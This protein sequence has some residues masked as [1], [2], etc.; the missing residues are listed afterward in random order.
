M[1][2]AV[3]QA[4]VSSVKDEATKK[5]FEYLDSH[6]QFD[7]LSADLHGHFQLQGGA[8]AYEHIDSRKLRDA[9]ANIELGQMSAGEREKLLSHL[10]VDERERLSNLIPSLQNMEGFK[11]AEIVHKAS[12][13]HKDKS[14][15]DIMQMVGQSLSDNHTAFAQAK[16]QIKAIMGHAGVSDGLKS[17]GDELLTGTL[18][19]IKELFV[20][21]DSNLM[22]ISG[23]FNVGGDNPIAGLAAAAAKAAI[24][25]QTK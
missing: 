8:P 21:K 18:K 7:T 20:P 9:F 5:F 2:E 17:G 25:S 16:E 4:V 24:T 13:E 11:A 3:T 23:G 14:M 12:E 1:Q 15:E 6:S 10:G 22:A 19:G